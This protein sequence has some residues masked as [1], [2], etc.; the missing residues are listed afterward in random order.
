M[1]SA[2]CA[3]ERQSEG[4]GMPDRIARVRPSARRA[5][6][7]PSVCGMLVRAVLLALLAWSTSSEVHAQQDPA[8]QVDKLNRDA[9]EAYNSLDI[10]KAAGMLDQALRICAQ[11][12]IGGPLYARTQLNFGVVFIGGMN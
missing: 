12:G 3:K 5:K 1:I 10:N 6:A 2:C 11:A 7:A 4:E 9:L 8:A